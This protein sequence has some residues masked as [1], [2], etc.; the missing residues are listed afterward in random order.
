MG[1]RFTRTFLL[2]F[3][4]SALALAT[5]S[6]AHADPPDPLLTG[7]LAHACVVAAWRASGLGDDDSR[8]DTLISR[9]AMSALVPEASV[10]AMQYWSDSDN[11]STATTTGAMTVYDIIG[12]HFVVDV[13]LTWKLDR[14]VYS[15]EEAALERIRVERHE[16]RARLATRTL[17]AL[18]ALSRA[19]ADSGEAAAGSREALEARLRAAE[20]VA[21]LDVLTAGWFTRAEHGTWSWP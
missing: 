3:V 5:A 11:T 19:R 4:A 14:L 9:A 20:A 7:A 13:H 21:T 17:D 16:A 15:G 12:S 1:P 8:I 6:P 10:R 18:F 2:T